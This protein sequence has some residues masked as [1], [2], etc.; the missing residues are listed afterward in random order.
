MG[1]GAGSN[2][3]SCGCG[4]AWFLGAAR[5]RGSWSGDLQGGFCVGVCLSSVNQSECK[6]FKKYTKN[7]RRRSINKGDGGDSCG[8]IYMKCG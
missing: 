6:K 2:M 5:L 1:A 8:R 7:T 4:L 3:C